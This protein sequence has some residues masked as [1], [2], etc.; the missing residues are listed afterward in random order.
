MIFAYSI[1]LFLQLFLVIDKPLISVLLI[2]LFSIVASISS[3]LFYKT[4]NNDSLRMMYASLLSDLVTFIIT[5]ILFV[6]F[7]VRTQQTVFGIQ[8]NDTE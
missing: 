5:L 3:I 2:V 6:I 8:T 7:F 1:S 4:K